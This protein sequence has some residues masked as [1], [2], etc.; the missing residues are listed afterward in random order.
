MERKE[1][2]K[3]ELKDSLYETLIVCARDYKSVKTNLKKGDLTVDK[4]KRFVIDHKQIYGIAGINSSDLQEIGIEDCIA[5]P[6][7]VLELLY[8]RYKH[9]VTKKDF[10]K[11]YFKALNKDELS[12]ADIINGEDR[13]IARCMLEGYVVLASANGILQWPDEKFWFW[14]SKTDPDLIVLRDWIKQEEK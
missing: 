3:F 2:M 14:Q 12:D 8:E 9:S 6:W 7:H 13:Y 1:K 10:K 11:T 5:D 4:T